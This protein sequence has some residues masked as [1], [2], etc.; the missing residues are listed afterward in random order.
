MNVRDFAQ[1]Y[2]LLFL[3]PGGLAIVLLLLS[4][5]MSL[6]GDT[7]GDTDADADTHI[8]VD[9]DGGTDADGESEN[10]AGAGAL[11]W[12][13]VGK[14]PLTLVLGALL[15][16][17]GFVG[18]WAVQFLRGWLHTPGAFVGPAVVIALLG[19]VGVARVT[20]GVAAYFV[21]KIETAA[22][23]R[24]SLVGQEASVVYPVSATGGRAFYYDKNAVLHD[25]TCRVRPGEPEIGKGR[26][27]VLAGYDP[28]SGRFWVEP[29]SF[30]E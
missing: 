12:I 21:P 28:P 4:S 5:V 3:V 15:L 9:A 2:Y 10:G 19:A 6:G 23:T 29:S 20:A 24:E 17:W 22:V 18:F 27:I 7:D 13:G 25:V 26:K 8:D 16:G 14:A 11:H 30:G 1:W